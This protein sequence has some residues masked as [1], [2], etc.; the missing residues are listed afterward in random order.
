MTDTGLIY[1]V[2]KCKKIKILDLTDNN[3]T[4]QSVQMIMIKTGPTVRKFLR[5]FQ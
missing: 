1:F 5:K 4:D 2:S 3:I